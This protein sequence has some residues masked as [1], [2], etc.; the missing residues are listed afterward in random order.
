MGRAE[1]DV[2][3]A[4]TSGLYAGWVPPVTY[5]PLFTMMGDLG[6]LRNNRCTGNSDTYDAII[7]PEGTAKVRRH[8]LRP[9]T[10]QWRDQC[11]ETR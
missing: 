3:C 4:M 9:R 10:S 11:R 5:M 7:C 6:F 1:C 8:A 2:L